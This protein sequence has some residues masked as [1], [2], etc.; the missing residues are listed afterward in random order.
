MEVVAFVVGQAVGL[1]RRLTVCLTY[2]FSPQILAND[3]DIAMAGGLMASLVTRA[4]ANRAIWN[5]FAET[6]QFEII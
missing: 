5:S 3:M 6:E 2:F 4:K 1:E